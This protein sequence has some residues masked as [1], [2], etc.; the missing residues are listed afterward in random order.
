ML[1]YACAVRAQW[2]DDPDDDSP[3]WPDNPPDDDPPP[4]RPTPTQKPTTTSATPVPSPTEDPEDP[5]A[6]IFTGVD[7]FD[8]AT[9]YQPDD[10]THH[11]TSP[12]TENLPNNTILA[13]WNDSAQTSGPLQIYQSTN[14]G[15]S[16]YAHGTAK[17]ATSGRKL[18]E[19]HLLFVP[20]L[21]DDAN[22]TLL[23]VN[24]VDAK[25]TNIELYASTDLGA[26]FDF[27]K[28]I[29]KGGEIGLKAVGE[30]HMVLHNDRLTV[31]Y[32]DR[33]DDKHRQK[34]SQKSTNSVY[35]AWSG[36]TDA[37][38]SSVLADQI[39]MGSVAKVTN[40][41]YIITFESEESGNG[42]S[43]LSSVKFK[44]ATS[45]ED[46]GKTSTHDIM[47][48][49]GLK[50]QGAPSVT[51]SSIGGQNGTVIVSGSTSNLLFVNQALGQGPWRAVSTTA[52]RAYGRE[53]HAVPDKR[54]LRITG[55]SE[56]MDKSSDILV[57]YMNFEKALAAAV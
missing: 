42:T 55:G 52:A 6:P 4:W 34:I 25:S 5:P 12:R 26:T 37:V 48:A 27:V 2:P 1:L 31:Y 13:V 9:V 30:P 3:G 14:N 57:T 10:S 38:A 41:Q 56:A 24:A 17:P 33:G 40:N 21:G 46:F 11:L 47:T 15:F 44:V 36:A 53:V 50:P 18:L 43:P 49:A 20:S 23:V 16:W 19:P 54:A 29:V 45:P 22:V 7:T 39:G 8:N 28:Q 35:G 32:S 51:W